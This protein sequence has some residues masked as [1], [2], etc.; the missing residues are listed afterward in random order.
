MSCRKHSPESEEKIAARQPFPHPG[1]RRV[2]TAT[3]LFKF[4]YSNAFSVAPDFD[5]F[6]DLI[7][8]GARLGHRFD[9]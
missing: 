2:A 3:E 7:P 4:R 8:Q 6:A 5:M 9:R 1:G